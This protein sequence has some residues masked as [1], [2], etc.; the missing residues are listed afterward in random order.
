MGDILFDSLQLKKMNFSNKVDLSFFNRLFKNKDDVGIDFIGNMAN[1][2]DEN[3]YIVVNSDDKEIG[4]LGMSPVVLNGLGLLSVSLY[5]VI[6]P[7]YRGN[8][9]ATLLLKEMY[10]YLKKDI[11]MMVLS[12]DRKNI[13]SRK[14]AEKAGFSLEFAY[15]DD[16]DVIYTKYV[17]EKNIKRS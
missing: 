17:N 11:D 3:A 16:D 1:V 4:Y 15:E 14:V 10:E 6:L 12:I 13:A 8:G 7:E 5:Y 2:Y 9:Y